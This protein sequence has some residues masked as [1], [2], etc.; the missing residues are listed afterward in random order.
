MNKEEEKFFYFIT[1]VPKFFMLPY[2]ALRQTPESILLCS[3]PQ[4]NKKGDC[5]LISILF[6]ITYAAV[7]NL[8]SFCLY[9]TLF[10]YARSLNFKYILELTNGK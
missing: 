1:F 5:S 3:M 7:V 10:F 2:F 8:L 4:K 6:C 9:H